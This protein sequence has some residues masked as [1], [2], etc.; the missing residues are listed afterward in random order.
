MFS[1][2]WQF[3]TC[4]QSSLLSLSQW[5]LRANGSICCWIWGCLHSKTP[6]S[7][8][9]LFVWFC[10]NRCRWYCKTTHFGYGIFIRS[11]SNLLRSGLISSNMRVIDIWSTV[12]FWC[13]KAVDAS[14]AIVGSTIPTRFV[15]LMATK[16]ITIAVWL[17]YCS[18]RCSRRR[19]RTRSLSSVYYWYYCR[20]YY[21]Y[22]WSLH[23]EPANV[24]DAR[25]DTIGSLLLVFPLVL[26]L[27]TRRSGRRLKH[28]AQIHLA[29]AVCC[30]WW[31]W[32]GL[33]FRTFAAIAGVVERCILD[34][35]FQHSNVFTFQGCHFTRTTHGRAIVQ[36]FDDSLSP[37][38][39]EPAPYVS[40]PFVLMKTRSSLNSFAF[41]L[42]PFQTAAAN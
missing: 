23:G 12:Y 2:H 26:L 14:D 9:V 42:P 10:I 39:L 38:L 8:R 36:T 20:H 29:Y 16:C 33:V 37:V 4:L 24:R 34:Y 13:V 5:R 21:C 15:I 28:L 3:W 40:F 1:H 41:P 35:L 30:C 18:D 6:D 32:R 25:P 27:S 11:F 31:R 19:S 17:R 7:C 22:C